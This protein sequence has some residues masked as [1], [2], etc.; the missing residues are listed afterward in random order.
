MN[1]APFA[2]LICHRPCVHS[3]EASTVSRLL[4]LATSAARRSSPAST[5]MANAEIAA[6]V[7]VGASRCGAWRTPSRHHAL[8]P[9]RRILVFAA[10]TCA[11]GSVLI[12]GALNH[13]HRHADSR[14]KFLD[15][16]FA[17]LGIEPRAVPAEEA[18][19][20]FLCQRASFSRR[21]RFRRRSF[22]FA[23]SLRPFSSTK[24]CGAISVMPAH[25]RIADAALRRSPRSTRHRNGRSGRRCRNPIASS[26]RGNTCLRLH[27]H[28]G[29]RSRQRDR[30]R[31]AIAGARIRKHTHAVAAASCSGKSPHRP[32]QP[33]PSCSSTS[34]GAAS[35]RGPTKRYSSC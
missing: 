6:T 12:V 18:A 27:V 34:V 20:T 17:E 5:R 21:F 7:A 13:L 19:S 30:A 8:R 25:A 31:R 14:Q 22:A 1:F 4:P 32:T 3:A 29:E 26:T 10:S 23:I 16:P 35:G 24:K 28:V 11:S 15:I 33:S 2:S 9:V